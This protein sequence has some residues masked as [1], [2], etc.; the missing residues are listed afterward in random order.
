MANKRENMLN[1]KKRK[2][3]YWTQLVKSRTSFPVML[4]VRLSSI[5]TKT[6]FVLFIVE[7]LALNIY[8][9]PTIYKGLF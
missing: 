5:K 8:Y 1:I 3:V 6:L 7:F 4:R 9:M 2:R